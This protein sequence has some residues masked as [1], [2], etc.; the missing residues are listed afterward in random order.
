MIQISYYLI[1]FSYVIS[2]FGIK[3]N[4]HNKIFFYLEKYKKRKKNEDYYLILN[5]FSTQNSLMFFLFLPIFIINII[6][7][8]LF[9]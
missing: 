9:A 1:K 6:K 8:T 7:N 5:I 2:V 3:I 4:L